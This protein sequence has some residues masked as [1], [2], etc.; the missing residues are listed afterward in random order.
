[1]AF[2]NT[3]FLLVSLL[4]GFKTLRSGGTI[5]KLDKNS[6][7]KI[8]K[9]LFLDS[10]ITFSYNISTLSSVGV[11]MVAVFSFVLARDASINILSNSCCSF[12]FVVTIVLSSSLI[13]LMKLVKSRHKIVK[14]MIAINKMKTSKYNSFFITKIREIR[15]KDRTTDVT[16]IPSIYPKKFIVKHK[17]ELKRSSD[18]FSFCFFYLIFLICTYQAKLQKHA[19]DI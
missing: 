9:K 14:E 6:I 4:L 2:C 3:T 1:M 5:I 7:S 15:E 16:V 8:T 10:V 11:V 13:S 12:L 17:F 18:L 19:E